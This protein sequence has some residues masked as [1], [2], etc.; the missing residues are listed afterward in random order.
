M[1]ESVYRQGTRD[2]ITIKEDPKKAKT[3]FSEKETMQAVA[4]PN[5][6]AGCGGVLTQ[7]DFKNIHQCQ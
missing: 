3:Y 6:N 7:I 4:D 5:I 1:P 2:Y